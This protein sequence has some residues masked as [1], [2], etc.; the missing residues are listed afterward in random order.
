MKKDLAG[1]IVDD[2]VKDFTDRRG[3]RQEW[4]MIDED[5]QEEIREEWKKIVIKHLTG[6]LYSGFSTAK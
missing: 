4:E 5:I 1:R 2:I 6:L 3:L